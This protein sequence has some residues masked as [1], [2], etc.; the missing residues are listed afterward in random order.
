MKNE[1]DELRLDLVPL[2]ETRTEDE[3]PLPYLDLTAEL[4]PDDCLFDRY[5]Q[6][7]LAAGNLHTIKGKMKVGK[8]AFGL[9]IMAAA[10]GGCCI[11]IRPRRDDLTVLWVDTEQDARTV[12]R[13]GKAVLRMAGLS[14]DTMPDRLKVL[15]LRGWGEPSEMLDAALR[16]VEENAPDLAFLDGVVDFCAAFNDEEQSRETIRRLEGCAAKGTTVLGL[17]HTNKNDSN[18]RGHLGAF[19]ESKSAEIYEVKKTDENIATVEQ[20][21][22]R[23]TPVES[24]AFAFGD[25]FVLKDV[26][27]PDVE[28]AIDAARLELR[29]DFDRLFLDESNHYDAALSYTYTELVNAFRSFHQKSIS[30]AKKAVA[31][32]TS[33]GVLERVRNGKS[34]VYKLAAATL[35]GGVDEEE[36]SI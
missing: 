7:M 26:E 25:D 35:F 17:I 33:L 34:F 22:S 2:H 11:G 14:E 28:D 3:R 8:S 27:T 20:P 32:A 36:D 19:M 16:A 31:R 6:G 9:V 10:L 21:F 29:Q 5:G 30:T 13:K 1:I 18:A 24:F 15:G 23:F 4:P 12:Q